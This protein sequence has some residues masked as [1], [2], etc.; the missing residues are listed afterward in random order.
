MTR[1]PWRSVSLLANGPARAWGPRRFRVAAVPTPRSRSAVNRVELQATLGGVP[2]FARRTRR[3]CRPLAPRRGMPPPLA[4]MLRGMGFRARRRPLGRGCHPDR[5]ARRAR[6]RCRCT[7]GPFASCPRRGTRLGVAVRDRARADL[8]GLNIG[9]GQAPGVLPSSALRGLPLSTATGGV[10]RGSANDPPCPDAAGV[11]ATTEESASAGQS[12]TATS[13]TVGP[14]RSPAA[15][16]APAR[17]SSVS[18]RS[19]AAPWLRALSARSTG[20][21]KVIPGNQ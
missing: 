5:R 17:S 2:G 16:S 7:C 6:G 21:S 11:P 15:S 9:E 12:W 18:T 4:R 20:G 10:D 1:P 14:A 3:T 13:S 8:R 19:A